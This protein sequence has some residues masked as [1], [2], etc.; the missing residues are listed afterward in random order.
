MSHHDEQVRE[1]VLLSQQNEKLTSEVKQLREQDAR[2]KEQLKK[3]P[4]P[5]Q[6][7]LEEEDYRNMQEELNAYKSGIPYDIYHDK[8][9]RADDD[10]IQQEFDNVDWAEEERHQ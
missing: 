8:S 5:F 7:V 4:T 1:N 3:I 10:E 6:T 9:L 2:N